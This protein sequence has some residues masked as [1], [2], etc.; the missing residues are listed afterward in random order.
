M[1][2]DTALTGN[3]S[4]AE[5]GLERAGRALAGG[6]PADLAA[7]ARHVDAI[8]AALLAM[9]RQEARGHAD[10]L[11]RLIARIDG[12]ETAAVAARDGAAGRLAALEV[13]SGGETAR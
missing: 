9:P 6:A 2:S 10:R 5:A 4:T 7:L 11:E 12:L 13:G 8:C 3:F 1:S